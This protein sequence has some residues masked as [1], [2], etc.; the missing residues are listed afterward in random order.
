MK[1][2]LA[3]LFFTLLTF[4]LLWDVFI[5]GLVPVPF[6]ILAGHYFPWKDYVWLGLDAGV[7]L[8]N[9]QLFDVVFQIYPWRSFSV[10][11]FM[12]GEFPLW[13]PYNLLGTPHLANLPTASL[14]PLN[15]IFL[16]I[17][18]LPAWV[19]YIGLQTILAGTFMYLFLRS[20]RL[21]LLA[22]LFGGTV[23]AFS[24]FLMMRYEFGIV[25]HTFLWVPLAL[26]SIEKW[27]HKFYFKWWLLGVFSLLFMF[28]GG[29]FQAMLYGFAVVISYL[30][31][32]LFLKR[33]Y[34]SKSKY[35]YI[36]GFLITPLLLASI[37][38]LPFVETIL[39]SSRAVGYEA[40]GAIDFLMS[41]QRL[42]GFLVPDFFGNPATA[43][44]WGEISYTEFAI[45]AGV[46][47][48]IF[49]LYSLLENKDKNV[50]F[51]AAIF[52]ISLLLLVNSQLS[53]LPYELNIPML[54][55]L[56]PSRLTSTINLSIAMLSAYGFSFF[57]GQLTKKNTSLVRMWYTLAFF[58]VVF[59]S[60]WFFVLNAHSLFPDASSLDNLII[61]KR[62]LILPSMIFASAIL[63][64]AAISTTRF[65]KY[66]PLGLVVLLLVTS[67]D[68]IRQAR[69]YNPF[70]SPTLAFA[71]TESLNILEHQMVPARVMITHQELFP[72]N[73]NLNYRVS[74]LD[75][76][77]SVH[78]SRI[79]ELLSTLNLEEVTTK[80][81]SSGRVTFNASET[82]SAINFVSTEYVY[83][84]DRK[85]EDPSFELIF[86]EGRTRL[87]R[88]LDAFPRAYLTKDILVK[89][90]DAEVLAE[91]LKLAEEG[92][93]GV[94]LEEHV[95][96]TDMPLTD[97]S[98]AI[99]IE[100]E[101]N[102][103][104]IKVNSNTDSILVLNDSFDKGWRVFINGQEN[105]LY[106]AN[107]ALRAVKVP[108]GDHAV[109]FI[110]DPKSFKI[111]KWVSIT[112]LIF[113]VGTIL[114]A[115]FRQKRS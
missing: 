91:V 7:P 37:A 19:L 46:M 87:Y 109:E 83:T 105:S 6:D 25:G 71:Q 100:Y 30:V 76:Y 62:N 73:T 35:L 104:T 39:N 70:V 21:T 89:S 97:D 55:S 88:N 115:R 45:Y 84:L 53:R 38:L 5:K 110:Y 9:F 77:D 78:P 61:S 74:M 101:P 72:A 27:I 81:V 103:V 17:P 11:T 50:I 85:L 80:T 98:E 69:K 4:F 23:F 26:F 102:K 29:Y 92:K 28:L 107:Y 99:I 111:G 43:N 67:F 49:A 40:T 106:K 31:Y 82:S 13:N 16:V 58:G 113:L 56:L 90:E 112:T 3:P 60:I 22:S 64:I 10:E 32:K 66:Y 24:S 51:W 108:L 36:I 1:K 65:R 57:H 12:N 2:Y 33:Q 44:F 95:E 14:Y 79:E 52:L 93:A 54:S 42:V 75:G 68:L 86:N 20:L 34:K 114:Y 96:M 48:F 41:P 59:A 47:P 15:I 8:K 94:V 18:F 63:V